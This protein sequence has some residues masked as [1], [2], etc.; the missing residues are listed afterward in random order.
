MAQCP[1]CA[2]TVKPETTVCPECGISLAQTS[3]EFGTLAVSSYATIDSMAPDATID[4]VTPNAPGDNMAPDATVDSALTNA[5]SDNL[6]PD[7][8]IDSYVGMAALTDDDATI[9]SD[10]SEEYVTADGLVT[11][12]DVNS[13]SSKP[14]ANDA[15]IDSAFVV[16]GSA[17]SV[18]DDIG[19][20]IFPVKTGG[21]GKI[22]NDG[23]GTAV[24]SE[25]D[26]MEVKDSRGKSGTA[27]RLQRMWQG[28]AGPSAN[29]LHTLQAEGAQ[30]SD[31]VF[32]RIAIR[33]V[34]EQASGDEQVDY[35]IIKQLGEGA[36]GKVYAARQKA[37]DRVVA[38]KMIKAQFQNNDDSKRKFFY[39][40][41]ITADLDHPN[42]VPIHE[43][44]STEDGL[45]FYAM[46]QISGTEWRDILET[47]SRDENVD[48]FMKVSDAVAFAHSKGIIHRDLKPANTMIGQYGEVFVTDWGL[49]VNLRKSKRFSPGGTPLYMSP[50]MAGHVVEKIGPASDIY[51]LGAILYHIVTGSGPHSGK[52]VSQCIFSALKNEIKPYSKDDPLMH[53]A[54]KAMAT[55][56]KDRYG[57]VEEMQVAIREYRR[58]AESIALSNRAEELLTQAIAS[59][60]Y[61]RFA[62]TIFGFRDAIE[63]WQNNAAATDG[64]K[65]ARLAYGQCAFD[66]GDYDLVL[67]TVDRSEAAEGKLYADA[68]QAKQVAESREKRF[69]TMRRAFAAV[70]LTAVVGLSGLTA[71]ALYSR[72]EAIFQKGEAERSS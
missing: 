26:I 16:A 57:S 10:S 20:V 65:R 58:H 23:H 64:L 53:I 1:K 56:P 9:V 7:A 27:G 18:G 70:V 59:K 47:K 54:M 52:T 46:K 68:L 2:A 3:A 42:I 8:T 37:V 12:S 67:Q 60:D 4:S 11:I 48:I 62:R 33:R 5:Q 14:G 51:V 6:A 66:K 69:K 39:E 13:S 24:Y 55:E 63:L 35:E 44:G 30:A 49:A 72:S 71:F 25:S 41:Q 40:A 34:V 22:A 32:D 43:L 31:S 38:L 50:E 15:T 19:T 45:L 21:A 17:P 28:A 29:P 36:M 61:E